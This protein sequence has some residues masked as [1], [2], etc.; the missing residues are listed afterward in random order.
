[1]AARTKTRFG[2]LLASLTVSLVILGL[3]AAGGFAVLRFERARAAERLS[4]DAMA[5]ALRA[6]DGVH[7]LLLA[8][9]AQVQNGTANPRLVAALDAKVDEATLRDLLLNEPWW[10]PF[11]R[12]VDGYGLYSD[13]TDTL[14]AASLPAGFAPANLVH[15][16]RLVHRSSSGFVMAADQTWAAAAAPVA[17]T[18]RSDW[19]V[20]VAMRG[21]E[22]GALAGV[23]DRAGASVALSDGHQ[24]LVATTGGARG[25]SDDLGPLKQASEMP[26]PGARLFGGVAVAAQPVTGGLRVLAAVAPPPAAPGAPP[27]PVPVL[28]VLGLGLGLSITSFVLLSRRPALALADSE[29]PEQPSSIARYTLVER[30]GLGGMAEIYAAVTS[31]EGNFRR[32][33][34]IK[35]LR[36]ELAV[37]PNAVAQFCDEANLLAAF[38]HPNIVAVYDFGRWKNQYFLAEE[39]VP[40]RDLGRVVSQCLTRYGSALSIDVVAYVAHEI[41]KALDHAHGL[42]NDQGRPLGIV[43]R[44]VSPENVMISPRG[45]VKLL[46]FGVVK[47]AEGRATKTEMGV[48]K[49]NVT[50]MSPEQARG[51]E[52]DNRADLYSL[53]LVIYHG[54]VGQPIYAAPTTYELLMQ[55]AA[56]PGAEGWSAIDRLPPPLAAVV[57]RATDPE[58][59][60][61]YPSARD[62]AADLEPWIGHGAAQIAALVGDLFGPDL[63]AEAHLLA[64][65][66]M[67]GSSETVARASTR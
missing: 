54:C 1:M 23:A 4:E 40:G 42:E 15:D 35:R 48:V 14:F 38:S 13:E 56:G 21:L 29:S 10:E 65:F 41:L 3:T 12:M 47:A 9:E 43:H 44:D 7:D 20:L 64:T 5:A 52:V 36:P 61:R 63:K 51:L 31:G 28:A 45:E 30:I 26:A 50:Y 53:A 33:V 59:D 27:L 17:L 8:L 22:T 37:D 57:R 66:P 6:A 32:P 24:L 25:G 34:V 11:R 18:S 19:P 55:A 46:D 58:L 60:R 2:A 67:T 39:Y 49:G 16:A 62:M